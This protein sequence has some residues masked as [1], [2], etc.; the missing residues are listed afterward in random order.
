[1]DAGGEGEVWRDLR[2]AQEGAGVKVKGT[3]MCR[4]CPMFLSCTAVPAVT[5]QMAKNRT[6]FSLLVL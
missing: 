6:W 4:R 3:M 2:E 1:V 5:N